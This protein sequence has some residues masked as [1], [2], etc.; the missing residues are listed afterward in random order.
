MAQKQFFFFK[1]IYLTYAVQ[2]IIVYHKSNT[3]FC[4]LGRTAGWRTPE[5]AFFVWA[6]LLLWDTQRCSHRNLAE[7][8]WTLG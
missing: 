1:Y 6:S 3:W 7:N 2:E 4:A 5:S 8:V